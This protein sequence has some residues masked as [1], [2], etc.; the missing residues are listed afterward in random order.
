M[1]KRLKL[2]KVFTCTACKGAVL[3]CV[4]GDGIHGKFMKMDFR[5]FD[6]FLELHLDFFLLSF[7]VGFLIR[8]IFEKLIKCF[9]VFFS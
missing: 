2:S 3:F 7:F 8:V 9:W 5:C 6:G 4:F 1:L